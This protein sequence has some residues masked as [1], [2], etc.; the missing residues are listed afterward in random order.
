M[1]SEEIILKY[2]LETTQVGYW[3]WDIQNDQTYLSPHFQAM[4]GYER[5]EPNMAEIWL[6]ALHPDDCQG[7]IKAYER[8]LTSRGKHP[9]QVRARYYHQNGSIVWMQCQGKV[10]AW[11]EVNNPLRVVGS[12]IDI[13]TQQQT[14]NELKQCQTALE[15]MIIEQATALEERNRQLADFAFLNSHKMRGPLARIL[16]LVDVLKLADSRDQEVECLRFI[17]QSAEELDQAFRAAA[18]ALVG[19]KHA[20][21]PA[22]G[23]V[24]PDRVLS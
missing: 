10:V 7:V 23:Q 21:L 11:D 22:N 16:G 18:H 17:V 20:E 14:E 2:A 8:H 3:D 4:L 13:T 6:E 1:F 5:Y 12:H 24:A 15:A 9:F 19:P